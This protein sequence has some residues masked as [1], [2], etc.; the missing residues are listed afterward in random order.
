MIK[1]LSDHESD[2]TGAP[3]DHIADRPVFF[4]QLP[5]GTAAPALAGSPPNDLVSTPASPPPT[6]ANGTINKKR[7][8]RLAGTP[9]TYTYFFF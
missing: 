3:D 5:T 2:G 8:R 6:S 9:G 4:E 7:K 1:L